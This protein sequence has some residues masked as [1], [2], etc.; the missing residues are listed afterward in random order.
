M[1]SSWFVGTGRPA[2]P[3]RRLGSRPG[4]PHPGRRA[5]RSGEHEGA[6]ARGTRC[7]P[8]FSVQ[9]RN[10]EIAF[11]FRDD[12][13]GARA[14]RSSPPNVSVSVVA[15]AARWAP[16]RRRRRRR[17]RRPARRAPPPLRAPSSC[18]RTGKTPVFWNS[19]GAL[20]R[21]LCRWCCSGVPRSNVLLLQGVSPRPPPWNSTSSAS[22]WRSR[23]RTGWETEVLPRRK[24]RGAVP[25]FQPRQ[26]RPKFLNF[27]GN[28]RRNGGTALVGRTAFPLHAD[29]A[30]PARTDR[31]ARRR[32]RKRAPQRH[33]RPCRARRRYRASAP[34]T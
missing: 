29:A 21:H 31:G 23:S 17:V 19:T 10:P 7:A 1:L 30:D 13:S 20:E 3:R 2:D 18:C 11:T 34:P 12:A 28:S 9:L 15:V 24:C 8:A 5:A 25:L 27:M 4:F 33:R 22:S 16:R 14:S 26:R 32:D 6:N